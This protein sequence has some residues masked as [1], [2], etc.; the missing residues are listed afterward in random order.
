MRPQIV[1]GTPIEYKNLIIQCWDADLLKR[2]NISTL[3]DKIYK[4][5][6]SAGK[7]IRGWREYTAVEKKEKRLKKFIL[8]RKHHE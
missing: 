4:I 5:Q 6:K 3:H 2:P 7:D 1:S 8:S